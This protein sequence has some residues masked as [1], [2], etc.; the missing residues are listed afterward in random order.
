MKKS[1]L[2]CSTHLCWGG[3]ISFLQQSSPVI[4]VFKDL[5][6]HWK[7][8]FPPSWVTLWLWSMPLCCNHGHGTVQRALESL[9][10]P[11]TMGIF[12]AV[13]AGPFG[14]WNCKHV[15]EQSILRDFCLEGDH[16]VSNS[17]GSPGFRS[18]W[19]WVLLQVCPGQLHLQ[20]EEISILLYQQLKQDVA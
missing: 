10:L 16:C 9:R 20:I 2:S 4:M 19:S 8:C 18:W 13:L 11:A 5:W 17:T 7:W 3:I 15:G 6:N 14:Q 12:T 1:S